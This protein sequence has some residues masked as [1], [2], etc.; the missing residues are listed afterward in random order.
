MNDVPQWGLRRA[1]LIALLTTIAASATVGAFALWIGTRGDASPMGSTDASIDSADVAQLAGAA[2]RLVRATG[3]DDDAIPAIPFLPTEPR[4]LAYVA[5]RVD[6]ERVADGWAEDRTPEEALRAAIIAARSRLDGDERTRVDVIEVGFAGRELESAAVDE[7]IGENL[8]RGVTGMSVQLEDGSTVHVPPTRMLADNRSFAGVVE[9]LLEEGRQ[10][11]RVALFE[12]TQALID[13]DTGSVTPLARGNVLV[14]ASAVT[15]GA[16]RGLADGMATWLTTQ[17]ANNGRMVYEYWPSRGEESDAN[18][19]IRQWMATTALVRVADVRDD[20]ALYDRVAHNIEYNLEISYT[21]VDGLAHIAD[22]DGDVKLGAV[23]LAALAISRHPDRERWATEEAALRRSVDELWNEDGSFTSFLVP[24]G[25][26][27]NQ[28]FY[29]GEALLLWAATLEEAPDG[30]LLAR[31]TKSFEYYREWHREQRNPA[32]IPWHTMAYEKVWQI[33]RDEEMRDFIFEMNDWLLAMQQ[34]DDTP[35]PDM[36][37]RFYAPDHP[38][39]G[40]PHASSDGVYLEGLIAAYRVADASEDVERSERYRVAIARVL[41][42]LMQLQFVDDIDMYYVSQRERV[43]GGLRTTEYDNRIRVDNVQHGL[44]GVLDVL[45][46]FSD[47][48]F[49]ISGP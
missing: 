14:P 15:A 44:L 40:P 37:G 9:Q 47:G 3:R 34:W 1:L 10:P 32:F 6:G 23:A 45:E 29:P 11:Q 38:E 17:L 43:E 12:A 25:R 28:N 24:E 42:H 30:A 13:L 20:V 27:D 19:M 18:N 36:A 16:V 46:T 39:Y 5:L 21:D 49:A 48:D 22:P 7:R 2:E 4:G 33:T 26:N 41:R 31:F 8:E 35:A